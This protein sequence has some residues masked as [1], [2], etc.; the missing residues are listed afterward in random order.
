[1]KAGFVANDRRR[2][3]RGLDGLRAVSIVCVLISHLLLATH[4]PG[5]L[6]PLNGLGSLGVHVFFVISGF[7]ITTL[8]VRELE[9]TGS[10]SLRRFI[11][12]RITRILPAYIVYL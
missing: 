11:W 7:L 9:R 6:G 5:W 12:R 10:L 3:I 4:A 1:M 2:D 8:L